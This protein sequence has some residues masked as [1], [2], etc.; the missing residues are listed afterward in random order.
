MIFDAH[1][2]HKEGQFVLNAFHECSLVLPINPIG[3]DIDIIAIQ[4]F[5]STLDELSPHSGL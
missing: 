4:A 2:Y 5:L 3:V 1:N